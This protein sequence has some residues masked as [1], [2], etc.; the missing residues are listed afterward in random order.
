LIIDTFPFSEDFNALEIRYEELKDVV[1]F[2]IASESL[3][4]HSGRPKL[5][6]L[7]NAE[8]LK[9]KMG[10]QLIVLSNTK[11]YLTRNPRT[12][13]ML[14]RQEITKYL[15]GLNLSPETVI[16]HSDCDEIPRAEAVL[17]LA[18]SKKPINVLFEFDFY[19]NYLNA[20][21]GKWYRARAISNCLFD[22]VQQMRADVFIYF[23][24]GTR[25]HNFPVMRL[26]DFWSSKR[27]PFYKFPERISVPKLEIVKNA[28]W[29]FNNLLSE[30][31][32]MEKIK[33]SS[34]TELSRKLSLERASYHY[35]NAC[36]VWTGE[37]YK[38]VQIDMSFPKCVR[39]NLDRWK[40]F[41]FDSKQA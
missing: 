14:Q 31:Q 4:S 12:R 26:T 16:I 41:I 28:G 25:R 32:I 29:H 10:K 1:D 38:I 18:K 17:E 22:S 6:H 21:S 40:D 13:E 39:E 15:R 3:Y 8:E 35:R 27:F 7:Q 36:D 11:S 9:K 23:A 19:V 24:S 20:K 2:F 33:N 5:L 34:H 37:E 30:D